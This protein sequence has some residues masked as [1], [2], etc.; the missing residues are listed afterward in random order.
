MYK[1]TCNNYINSLI[2]YSMVL[3][4]NFSKFNNFIFKKKKTIM[5]TLLLVAI[6]VFILI[7]FI[8]AVN[9]VIMDTVEIKAKSLATKAMNTAIENT[10]GGVLDYNDI[11]RISYDNYGNVSLI[12]ANNVGINRLTKNLALNTEDMIEKYGN[13]LVY[14]PLGT[15]TGIP[16]LVGRGPKIKLKMM[17][18]GAVTCKFQ[19]QFESAGINQT[20]HKI[21]VNIDSNIGIVLPLSSSKVNVVQQVLICET[22]VVGQVPEVYLYSDTLD[23]LLNFVPY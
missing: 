8:V 2:I 13:D 7:G 10:I 12:Q 6:I 1:Y 22:I 4:L 3:S 11:I 23:T 5:V 21:Y 14:V 15:F 18:I 16:I 19:S 20:I 9:P 17:P